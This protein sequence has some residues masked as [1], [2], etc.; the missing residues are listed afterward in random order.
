MPSI[1]YVVGSG[2]SGSTVIERVLTTSPNVTAVGEVHAL[3]RLPVQDLLCSCGQR[4]PDCSFWQGALEHAQIGTAEIDRLRELEWKVVRNKFLLKKRYDLD[5]IRL[6]PDVATFVDLQKRLFDGISQVS[7][8]SIVL[9]SSKAGPRAWLLA[10]GLSPV[11]LH[12]YRSAEDVIASWRKPKFEP[13]TGSLMKKPPIWEA[14]MDWVKVEQAARSLSKRSNVRR[15]NYLDFANDPRTAL[16]AALDPVFPGLTAELA[17]TSH[18][19]VRPSTDYH[20]VL[21]NPD[22]FDSA[23]IVI[24]PKKADRSDFSTTERLSIAAVGKLLQTVYR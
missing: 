22:R 1:L 2:R 15:I 13:S 20:S 18:Q 9:D 17:W 6:D 21:G 7:G 12:A 19:S 5:A 10:V 4:V 3:W 16:E 24:K 11:F 14:A 8:A 23:D